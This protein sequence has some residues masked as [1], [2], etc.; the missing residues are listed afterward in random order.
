[1]TNLSPLVLYCLKRDYG[2]VV[3]VYH[4]GTSTVDLT[5]G[6]KTVT[7]T[8]FHIPR[9]VIMPARMSRSKI[10]VRAANTDFL[11]LADFGTREFVISRKDAKGLVPTVDDWI[12]YD[13][14]KYQM[15]TIEGFECGDGWVIT[16]KEMPGDLPTQSLDAHARVHFHSEGTP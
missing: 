15:A 12:V 1:M 14:K 5:T 6:A 11:N 2:G 7:S 10:T 13:R 3:D 9:A 4:L 8:R 16:G